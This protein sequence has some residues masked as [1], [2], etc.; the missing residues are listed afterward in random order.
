[1]DILF[2]VYVYMDILILCLCL[3]EYTFFNGSCN[4]NSMFNVQRSKFNKNVSTL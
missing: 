4:A 3:H 1:M 2:Y